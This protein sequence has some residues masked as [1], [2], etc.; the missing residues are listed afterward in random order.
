MGQVPEAT[1]EARAA[2]GQIQE[3]TSCSLPLLPSGMLLLILLA[4][5]CLYLC[6]YKR[7]KERPNIS[8]VL[9]FKFNLR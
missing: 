8:H 9:L 7:L 3:L 2:R 5:L 4:V 6:Y 1:A